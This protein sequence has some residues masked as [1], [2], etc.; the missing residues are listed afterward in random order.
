MGAAILDFS[1]E[2]SFNALTFQNAP[3]NDYTG[4]YYTV[5]YLG[6]ARKE[7]MTAHLLIS[8]I[9]SHISSNI[10]QNVPSPVGI[11]CK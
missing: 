9:I 10:F 7:F 8:R 4:T 11:H 6:F 5:F 3:P 2:S 1:I